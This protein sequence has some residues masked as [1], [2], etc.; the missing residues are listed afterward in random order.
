MSNPKNSSMFNMLNILFTRKFTILLIIV[1]LCIFCYR[2]FCRFICPLGAIYGLFNRFAIIGVK[3]NPT[4]CTHCGNCVRSCQMDVRHVGDHECISCGECMNVC[5]AGAISL[6]AGGLT[7]KAP[8]PSAKAM[9]ADPG[10]EQAVKK[11]R[12]NGRIAWAVAIA[13]LAAV[14]VYINVILPGREKAASGSSLPEV[15][16]ISDTS[17]SD[18]SGSDASGSGSDAKDTGKSEKP[19]GDDAAAAAGTGE[20]ESAETEED[21]DETESADAAKDVGKAESA[22][23]SKEAKETEAAV[24]YESSAP[25]GYSEGDQLKDFEVELF[26]GGTFHLKDKRGKIVIINRW[27]TWCPSCVAEIPYFCQI[28][29]ENPDVYVL[30]VHGKPIMDGLEEY[31]DKKQWGLDVVADSDNKICEIVNGSAT[32]PQTT[33]LNA[34]GEVIYNL[35]GSVTYEKLRAL[36]EKARQSME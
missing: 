27:A 1:L 5:A 34:R 8:V 26:G 22:D 17:G 6:K 28:S 4:R 16:Q 19:D 18:T 31:L 33:V 9:E 12:S 7:L 14:L 36:V 29:E 24:S 32:L 15:S 2:A 20:T 3:V 23:A 21:T 30:L 10:L 25:V 35:S 11:R 13:A